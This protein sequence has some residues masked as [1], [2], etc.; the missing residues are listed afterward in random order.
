MFD[1]LKQ[2]LKQ[3]LRALR[4]NRLYTLIIVT[5]LTLGISG[6]TVIFSAVNSILLR[7]LP[8][9]NADR[10]VYVWL[11]EAS[12]GIDK[13]PL[14]IPELQDYR[15]QSKTLDGVAAM[16]DTTLN[17]SFA[18]YPE[19]ISVSLITSNLLDVLGAKPL[20]GRNFLPE[21]EVVGN[22]RVVILSHSLWQRRFGGNPNIIGQ[23]ITAN[24]NPRVVV[25]IMPSDFKFP[26]R[27]TEIWMPLAL[28]PA[29]PETR[30][31]R[32]V[33]AVALP[34]AGISLDQTQT[35]L[36][37]IASRLQQEY[38][39]NRG[40]TVRVVPL[41][42]EVFGTIKL[43]LQM[44][45]SA[46]LIVLLIVCANVASLMLAR[47]A[48]REREMAIRAALGAGRRRLIWQ[49]MIESIVLALTAGVLGTLLSLWFVKLLVAYGVH[50]LPQLQD[51]GIDRRALI[52]TAGLSLLTSVL[53]GLVPA[54]KASKPELQ[55]SLKEGRRSTVLSSGGRRLFNM[56]VISEIT[57]SFILLI[58][59]GLLL[60]SFIQLL[61]V[62]PGF[63]PDNVLTMEMSLT[64]PKYRADSAAVSTFFVQL[65]QR[66]RT[67]PGVQTTGA[68]QSIPLG[69]GDRYYM[70]VDSQDRA[71]DSTREGRPSVAFFQ[72]TPE[73]FQAIGTPL[74]RGRAFVDQDDAQHPPVAII[75]ERVAQVY[76]PNQDPVGKNIHLG[77]PG[78][79][80]PWL[81]VVGVVPDIKFEDLNTTPAMQVYTPH[82]QG[83][84]VQAPF[85]RMVLAVRT[86]S[87]PATLTTA[88]RE[89]VRSIDPNQPVTKIT[90][91]SQLLNDSLAQRR[92]I[93]LLLVVF[94]SMALLL[95][96]IGLYGTLSYMVTQRRHEIATRM[97]LGAQQRDVLT[98]ILR[99]GM[100]LVVIG[101]AMG[102]ITAYLATRLVESLL[103]SVSPND[104]FT[105]LGVSLL[106]AIISLLASFVPAYK[107][108]KVD[109]IKVLRDG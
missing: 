19:Q 68:T 29:E 83:L 16:F 41:A 6:T 99:Q 89:Q 82:Q 76:F 43:P 9:A 97:A 104:P 63:R 62:D 98:L 35:D 58:G 44:L 72:I 36:S 54:L 79:W 2:N 57:L 64:G 93:L 13:S 60:R 4:N 7:P 81:S 32:W 34:K 92:F 15:T 42:T 5:M 27:E 103:Y 96:A 74:L 10:I 45:L 88:I 84:Q 52:F 66:I 56:L 87:D 86:T 14:S 46:T 109:P 48:V 102:L 85:T 30:G 73:Y 49:L 21:E 67:L 33:I 18:D 12:R 95:A 77:E 94:A 24:G 23:S 17:V 108:S 69:S 26:N 78:G 70:F 53:F 28:N 75:S 90:T 105:F 38:P 80:G 55:E 107:A 3:A 91:L 22:H 106:I 100:V 25:G 37:T 71:D 59:A 51:V 8:Y 47:A 31:S 40:V 101:V 1:S 20:L 39:E 65:M 50:A 61:R 11:S